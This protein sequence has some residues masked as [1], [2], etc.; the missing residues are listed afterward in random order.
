MAAQAEIVAK[1]SDSFEKARTSG[2]LLFFPSTLHTHAENG[3]E[4]R[5]VRVLPALLLIQLSAG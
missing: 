3:V 1:L 5:S 2:D 4:V